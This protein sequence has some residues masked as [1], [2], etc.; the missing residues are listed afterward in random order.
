MAIILRRICYKYTKC[1]IISVLIAFFSQIF[2]AL[3]FFPSVNDNLLKKN[4]LLPLSRQEEVSARKINYGLSDDEDFASNK[5]PKAGSHLRVEELDFQ[6]AC[7]IHSREAVS[8]IHRAKTQHC[9]HIIVNKT[10]LIQ[11][12]HFYPDSLPSFCP[13]KG[14][15]YGQYLGCYADEK[16]LR[17]L[18][19]FYGNYANTNSRKS[20]LDICIQGGFPYAGVQYA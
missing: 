13:H 3:K 12:G 7:D 19:G 2:I 5:Q 8:A 17:L 4:G 14:K 16:K 20:C 15:S 1:I 18:S 6:P 10:C 9:K 11:E